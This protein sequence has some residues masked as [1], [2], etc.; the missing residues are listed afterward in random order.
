MKILP[1]LSKKPD[2]IKESFESSTL[3]RDE[4]KVSPLVNYEESKKTDPFTP[5]FEDGQF[6]DH[7]GE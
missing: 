4:K 2:G 6:I 5:P 3:P 1:S 7:I